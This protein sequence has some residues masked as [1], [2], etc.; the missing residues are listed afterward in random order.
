MARLPVV[1]MALVGVGLVSSH[2]VKPVEDQDRVAVCPGAIVLGETET[3]KVGVAG[4]GAGAKTLRVLD[5]VGEVPPGPVQYTVCV[6]VPGVF[7]TEAGG[8]T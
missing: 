8:N 7:K 5:T 2:E 1:F 3:S 6:Y 4:A